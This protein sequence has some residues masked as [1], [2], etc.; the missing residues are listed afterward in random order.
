[1]V[2][3]GLS[4]FF[5]EFVY[6][7]TVF[8]GG[9]VERP[10]V[11]LRK[12]LS[13][14]SVLH[15]A[16]SRED[17]DVANIIRKVLLDEC[18]DWGHLHNN[19]TKTKDGK[20]SLKPR[21]RNVLDH[22]SKWYTE[23]LEM[24]SPGGKVPGVV[25]VPAREGFVAS[26]FTPKGGVPV[27]LFFDKEELKALCELLGSGGAR[28]VEKAVLEFIATKVREIQLILTQ[29]E[30][31]LRRFKEVYNTPKW[32]E[33]LRALGGLDKLVENSIAIGN[34]LML[35]R[36]LNEALGEV[37]QHT[38]PFIRDTVKMGCQALDEGIGVEGGAGVDAFKRLAEDLGLR[39]KSEDH[40]LLLSLEGCLDHS[41]WELLPYAYAASFTSEWWKR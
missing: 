10:T 26:N 19:K 33:S 13:C 17:I 39:L 36:L 34:A 2:Q 38:M 41:V 14:S 11:A 27:D 4:S 5:Q 16:I 12:L 30:K 32:E 1:Y 40:S 18:T 22:I 8:D 31:I 9:V 15:S 7:S 21:E 24:I 25:Y 23:M 35:R 6:S 3:D 20:A 29:K 37:Y 28:A